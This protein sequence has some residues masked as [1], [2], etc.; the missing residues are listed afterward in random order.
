M[1]ENQNLVEKESLEDYEKTI[2][3]N[4]QH[5]SSIITDHGFTRMGIANRMQYFLIVPEA[6]DA[7]AAYFNGIDYPELFKDLSDRDFFNA[8][9]LLNKR[10]HEKAFT[11]QLLV[12]HMGIPPKKA[13]E[14]LVLLTKYHL[15]S[16]TQI[17]MDDELHTAYYFSPTPSFLAL[18]IFAREIIDKPSIFAYYTNP[19]K[20]PYL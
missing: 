8:C 1:M 9:V 7:E 6:K 18:L 17:E 3:E 4:A 15:V 5:Y 13:D 10:N 11:P 16:P 19:R 12:K 20:K 14:I 2:D